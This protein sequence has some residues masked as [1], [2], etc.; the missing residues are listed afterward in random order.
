[1]IEARRTQ[2]FTTVELL[3]TIAIIAVIAALLLP[4]L[5]RG[6]EKG[7]QIACL[8]HEY[9]IF[10]AAML[11]ADDNEGNMCGERMS[12]ETGSVW[13][14]PPKPNAGKVWTWSFAIRPYAPGGTNLPNNLWS[15]PT[16]PP[17]WTA[18]A[19]DVDDTVISSYGIAE[20]TF[21]GDFGST[22]V[23]SYHIT[24]IAKP[25]QMIL[26]GETCWSGPG[27]SARFLD[28]TNATLGYWHTHRGN[29]E[30]WDGHGEPLRGV[31]TVTDDPASCMWDHKFWN[32]S[33]HITARDNAR[34]EYKSR[35]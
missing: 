23:H 24:S 19:E 34:Q 9:Q 15:C 11:Y 8:D 5:S 27:I 3:V 14:A 18:A 35:H 12:T 2:A 22:G 20:D 28:S 16:R 26:L 29:Y 30:F 21:W 10:V 6:K 7:R 4:V 17:D 32:H 13:P 33:I 31:A 25:A 1:M